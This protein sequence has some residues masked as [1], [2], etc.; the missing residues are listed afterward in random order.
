MKRDAAIVIII[1]I[2]IIIAIIPLGIKEKNKQQQDISH[3][4]QFS[5]SQRKSF[6]DELQRRDKINNP[7]EYAREKQETAELYDRLNSTPQVI[8]GKILPAEG[9]TLTSPMKMGI[10]GQSPQIHHLPSIIV[11]DQMR[12]I[13][14]KVDPGVYEIVLCETS[15]HPGIRLENII[16]EEGKPLPETVIQIGDVSAEVTV[17]N[18]KGDPVKDA[19]V[20][21]GK[22][23]GGTNPDMYA[24]RKGLSDSNGNYTAKNLT[25]GKYVIAV[26]TQTRNGSSVTSLVSGQKNQKVQTLTHNNW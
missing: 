6:L 2:A 7:E 8:W 10:N 1:V 14:P 23:S 3:N 25:D 21:V 11:D 12:F 15:D 13:F 9:Q 4:K 26:H 17:L 24:W 16:I 19:Q 20:L 22:S 18:K 5:N